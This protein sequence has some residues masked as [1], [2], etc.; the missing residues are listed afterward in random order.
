M[1]K[2]CH[3]CPFKRTSAPGYLGSGSYQPEEFLATCEDTPIP[4]HLTVD[5]EED[6]EDAIAIAGWVTPCTGS[7]QYMR[8]QSKQPRE[9]EYAKL[10]SSADKNPDGF[11]WRHEFINHHKKQS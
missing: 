5:W 6:D 4:C 8:N 9:R 11:S 10:V 7:L 1:K 2:P 3:E